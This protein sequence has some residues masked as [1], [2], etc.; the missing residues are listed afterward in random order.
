MA[1]AE[2]LGGQPCPMCNQKTLTLIE[3][4]DEI[5]YFGKV[6]IFSMHC[7]NCQFH[8]ADVEAV[9]PKDPSKCTIEISG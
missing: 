9:E 7:S 8:K 3:K 2:E 4:E 5:P 6:Y 1:E